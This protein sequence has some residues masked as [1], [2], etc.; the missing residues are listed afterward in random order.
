MNYKILSPCG[1]ETDFNNWNPM[2][3]SYGSKEYIPKK[4]ASKKLIKSVIH[5]FEEWCKTYHIDSTKYP[6]IEPCEIEGD[7]R[8]FDFIEDCSNPAK[9]SIHSI[10]EK[11]GLIYARLVD[12][13]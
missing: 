7:W 8:Q 12:F 9:I 6:I 11:D 4:Q 3:N 5:E 10:T 1:I 2:Q 13:A